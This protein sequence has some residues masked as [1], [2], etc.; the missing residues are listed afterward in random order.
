MSLLCF[1]RAQAPDGRVLAVR[2][3]ENGWVQ[4]VAGGW[5]T[6]LVDVGAPFFPSRLLAPVL[7]GKIVGIGSNYRDHAAEL[8]RPL[9][10]VP[11]IFLKAI[12]ALNDPGA[13]IEIP[14]G[15][16]RVDH[17]AELGVV[18]GRRACRVALDD[19]LCHVA[20]YTA[21]NDVTARDLQRQDGVFARAKGFDSFCPVGPWVVVGLDPAD[22]T[23][24]AWVDEELRQ[25]GNTRDMVFDVAALIAF[26]SGVMT[27]MPGDLIATGTPAGVGPLRAGQRVR[28]EVQGV[29]ML[30]SPVVDRVDRKEAAP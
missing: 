5:D 16:E 12:S 19:A 18:I 7:P 21:V 14:P 27:L 28:V 24:R 2:R 17:E 23:I 20:G 3:L 25:D 11:K 29:G 26:V 6:G 13:P 9:P 22:L 15:T 30:E 10:A 1:G 4:P 8:D